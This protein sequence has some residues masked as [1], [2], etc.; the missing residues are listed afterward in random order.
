LL[1]LGPRETEWRNTRKEVSSN[2]SGE[3]LLEKKIVSQLETVRDV[4][5][6]TLEG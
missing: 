4:L 5:S 2:G 1:P 3:S 6:E